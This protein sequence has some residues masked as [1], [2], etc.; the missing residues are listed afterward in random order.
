MPRANKAIIRIALKGHSKRKYKGRRYNIS[1]QSIISRFYRKFIMVHSE[2]WEWTAS[3]KRGTGY[4][5]FDIG[6]YTESAHRASWIIHNGDIPKEMQVLHHCDNRLCVNPNH[7]FLG[8]QKDNMIDMI[9][10]FREKPRKI[11]TNGEILNI[12]AAYRNGMLQRIIGEKYK[13]SR[14]TI[15]DIVRYKTWRRV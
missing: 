9:T 11:L 3:L 4:G 6:G 2:C 13:V 1:A 8:T 15:S 7:L 5:Q 12:R 10:K 14:Q